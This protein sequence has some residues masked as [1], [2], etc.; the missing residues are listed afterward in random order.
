MYCIVTQIF[1]RVCVGGADEHRTKPTG[2]RRGSSAL[3][4]GA[5]FRFQLDKLLGHLVGGP[6]GQDLHHRHAGLV[7]VNA[8]AERAPARAAL[9]VGDVSQLDHRHPD[10]PVRPAEAVVLHR[11]LELIAVRGL[12]PQDAAEQRRPFKKKK[13]RQPF[14]SINRVQLT[15]EKPR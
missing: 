15:T 7:G 13:K 9:A 4:H 1:Y 14:Y 11:H 2:R 3:L 12:L 6:L 8:R 10:H 5:D